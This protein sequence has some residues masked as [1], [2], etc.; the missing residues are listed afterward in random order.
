MHGAT[1]SKQY[2]CD[3][4]PRDAVIS[5]QCFS[6]NFVQV[7]ETIDGESFLHHQVQQHPD[8]VTEMEERYIFFGDEADIARKLVTRGRSCVLS[9]YF[10]QP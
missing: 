3:T 7:R 8:V 1:E 6:P 10:R 9:A 5:F 2:Q 4:K